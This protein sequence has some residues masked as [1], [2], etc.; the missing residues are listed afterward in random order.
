MGTRLRLNTGET[1][2]SDVPSWRYLQADQQASD[3]LNES[4][5]EELLHSG[6]LTP[7]SMVWREGMADWMPLG[8][9][10]LASLIPA[11]SLRPLPQA[12]LPSQKR[13]A[14]MPQYEAE[15]HIRNMLVAG[16]IS[17]LVTALLAAF[18]NASLWIDVIVN[19]LLLY[20]VYRAS[21]VC[22]VMVLVLYLVGVI[23]RIA[24]SGLGPVAVLIPGI[25]VYFYVMGIRGV[26]A[27]HR[28]RA[29][30]HPQ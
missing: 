24:G 17:V 3:P 7:G 8:T 10:P 26:F 12:A 19:L 14:A 9:S 15:R 21:R 5:V 2:R 27:L 22:A 6:V 25:I 29:A 23:V 20:G 4:A 30:S 11:P 1:T 16:G 13:G 18:G 28:W